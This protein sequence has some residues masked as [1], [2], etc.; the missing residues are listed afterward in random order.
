[1]PVPNLLNP[2]WIRV[3]PIAKSST[4][5]D[6]EAREPLRTATKG[7]VIYLQAQVE[8]GSSREPQHQEIGAKEEVSGY[9]V[10]TTMEADRVGY[11]PKRGDLVVQ[12][13]RRPTTLYVTAH[14]DAGHWGDTDGASLLRVFFADRRPGARAPDQG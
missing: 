4:A 7:A 13:G 2:V 5:Y 10:T 1:M 3:K 6:A 11:S 12:V 9:F 14:E 8:Y